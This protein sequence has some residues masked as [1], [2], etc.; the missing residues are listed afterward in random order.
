[1]KCNA[2]AFRRMDV[3]RKQLLAGGFISDRE[4]SKITQRIN[5]WIRDSGQ[6]PNELLEE[7]TGERQRKYA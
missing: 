5:H 1:M 3:A 6:K 4:N 7:V 2:D